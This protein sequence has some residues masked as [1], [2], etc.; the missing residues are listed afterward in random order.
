LHKERD[1]LSKTTSSYPFHTNKDK[2]P[3]HTRHIY[4]FHQDASAFYRKMLLL[5]GLYSF[6]YQLKLYAVR[7]FR[8]IP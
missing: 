4:I 3:C 7:G 8:V 2:S 6:L 1:N 5:Y